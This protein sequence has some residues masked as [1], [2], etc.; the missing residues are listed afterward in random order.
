M[1]KEEYLKLL[2]NVGMSEYFYKDG[3][4]N[5]MDDS[6]IYMILDHNPLLDEDEFRKISER[7][8]YNFKEIPYLKPPALDPNTYLDLSVGDMKWIGIKK[9]AD[10]FPIFVFLKDEED[11]L[12]GFT[13]EE[14]DEEALLKRRNIKGNNARTYY[15]SDIIGKIM[16]FLLKFNENNV[17]LSFKDDYPLLMTTKRFSV[18]LAP[19]I[20]SVLV[21]SFMVDDDNISYECDE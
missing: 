10:K 19:K 12:M 14:N 16:N 11:S 3:T 1:D 6:R 8:N 13:S 4:L 21:K 18:F 20:V 15:N 7:L 2:S 5:C 9:N 17:S